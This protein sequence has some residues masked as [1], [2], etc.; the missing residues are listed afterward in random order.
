MLNEKHKHKKEKVR[1][2]VYAYNET[3]PFTSSCSTISQVQQESGNA[4]IL[5]LA[6]G[7]NFDMNIY[8]GSNE[9]IEKYIF[10]SETIIAQTHKMLSYGVKN[11]TNF[12]GSNEHL[13][14]ERVLLLS[15]KYCLLKTCLICSTK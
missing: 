3:A 15:S 5:D 7:N 11:F 8:D 4:G 1:N 6:N 12:I 9:Q 13:E 10:I 2:S 14:G